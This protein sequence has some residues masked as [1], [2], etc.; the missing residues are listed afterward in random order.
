MKVGQRKMHL[1]VR[2]FFPVFIR[3]VS[4]HVSLILLI[5]FFACRGGGWDV[6]RVFFSSNFCLR[7]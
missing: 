4:P 3:V 6:E 7:N 5:V 2:Y 1:S